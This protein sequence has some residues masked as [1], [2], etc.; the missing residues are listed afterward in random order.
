VKQGKHRDYFTRA[1]LWSVLLH[2]VLVFISGL[3]YIGRISIDFAKSENM[4]KVKSMK[5]ENAEP[6]RHT[7]DTKDRSKTSNFKNASTTAEVRPLLKDHFKEDKARPALAQSWK[8]EVKPV[9]DKP[10]KEL[11]RL[12]KQATPVRKTERQPVNETVMNLS[13]EAL[14]TKTTEAPTPAMLFDTT[15]NEDNLEMAGFTPAYSG[16]AEDVSSW[17][18]L[19]PFTRGNSTL[20]DTSMSFEDINQH[21]ICELFTFTDSS[22]G[23][24]YFRVRISAGK[25]VDELKRVPKEMIFLVDSSLSIRGERLV[26]FKK[27]LNYALTHLDGKDAFNIRVFKEN[28]ISLNDKSLSPTEENIKKALEFVG[29]ITAGEGTDAYRAF[30]ESIHAGNERDASYL[31][32]LSDGKPTQG[33]IDSTRI[34]KEISRINNGRKGIFAF[35]GG[36]NVNRYLLDFIAYKNRG[37]SE[38]SSK[39]YQIDANMSQMID[40]IQDPVLLDVRYNLGGVDARE[41]YPKILPD[42]FRNAEINLYGKY[43][44]EN[45]LILRILAEREGKTQELEVETSFD[46]AQAGDESIMKN[47]AYN[48][49]YDLI[50]RLDDSARFSTLLDGIQKIS[51]KFHI[52][53]PYTQKNRRD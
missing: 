43:S 45:R 5:A 24:K 10:L 18:S 12:D 50:G 19:H 7:S 41:V 42:F 9:K 4:F 15:K 1:I 17:Q 51:D 33:E 8:P 46:Q 14:K 2:L 3:I 48:K 44:S 25:K 20:M 21:L 13:P 16:A 38:Y 53:T 40:K 26:E 32:L 34:I 22:D 37:W 36:G 52:Q 31:F 35:S 11:S 39:I 49:I 6:M 30:F 28:V 29:Q 23:Q 47:W 27:G